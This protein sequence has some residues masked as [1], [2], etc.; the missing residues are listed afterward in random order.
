MLSSVLMIFGLK[1]HEKGNVRMVRMHMQGL[2]R[3]TDIRGG[4][5]GLRRSNAMVA[6]IVFWQ[7][8]FP[9]EHIFSNL[10][11]LFPQHVR[12]CCR[13]AISVYRLCRRH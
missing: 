3:M 9:Y 1:K 12:R 10:T 6:N 8:F 4:I 13:R 2:K 5:N 11:D 7:V